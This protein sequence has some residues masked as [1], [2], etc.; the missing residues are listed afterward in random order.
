[1][2][3]STGINLLR[4]SLSSYEA[5]VTVS[6][7]Q[8]A[9]KT[10]VN[11]LPAYMAA[12]RSQQRRSILSP[13]HRLQW[14]PSDPSIGTSLPDISISFSSVPTAELLDIIRSNGGRELS[15]KGTKIFIIPSPIPELVRAVDR[16]GAI[17]TTPAA[18]NSVNIDALSTLS[19]IRRIFSNFLFTHQYPAFTDD[20]HLGY[21]AEHWQQSMGG[22]RKATT[23]GHGPGGSSKRVRTEGEREPSVEDDDM[24]EQDEGL[25]QPGDQIIYALP[26]PRIVSAWGSEQEL[27]R[28]QG[29]FIRFIEETQNSQGEKIIHDVLVR[30]FLGALGESSDA[31]RASYGRIKKDLGVLIMTTI[32][33]ELAHMA[34]CIDIGLQAQAR[35]WPLISD[36]QYL[37]CVLLGA[38]FQISAYDTVH[39]PV[40]SESLQE[41]IEHAGSHRSSL[42]SIA[43]IVEDDPAEKEY[44]D[45]VGVT[46]MSKLRN[47]LRQANL[48]S[49]DRDR[50]GTLAR[51]LRFRP[52]SLNLSSDN[53]VEALRLIQFPEEELAEG[54]PISPTALFE[55]NRVALIWSAFG[56]LAPTCNFPGGAQVNLESSKDLPK[57]IGFRLVPLK[58]AV[59]DIEQIMSQ[60]KF[61]NTSMNRRSG[62]FKDRM[63]HG[64]D[65]TKILSAL[66]SAV[67]VT[68]DKGKKRVGGS[69]NIDPGLFDDGF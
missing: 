52:R 23:V 42:F 22:K 41:R 28:G 48:S 63:Y 12:Y 58:D 8:P 59:I 27:P 66:T 10:Y 33:K 43:N 6:Y 67:G 20:T 3:L 34:K 13:Y 56:D 47:R 21:V 7:N 19:M 35:I 68:G 65:A 17:R 37:G 53:I 46:S 11:F 51:G 45:I 9:Y 40:A 31:V 62:A 50:I 36:G 38:G 1:M 54:F 57:H 2:S 60:K 44:R 14:S 24:E 15:V 39:V 30:Y 69:G 32:G 49:E 4:C 64:L 26:P 5:V 16:G 55:D 18:I 61:S 29:I 25:T